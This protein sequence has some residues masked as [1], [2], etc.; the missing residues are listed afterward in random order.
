MPINELG[1][2]EQSSYQQSLD[3]GFSQAAPEKEQF[4]QSD[5]SALFTAFNSV[6][7][8][9]KRH[10]YNQA[11][12]DLSRY[13]GKDFNIDNLR[14]TLTEQGH[15]PS[16]I[17]NTLASPVT[18]WLEAE[19]R[20]RY[21]DNLESS[22]RQINQNYS[23]F[24]MLAVGI[25]MA[26]VDIDSLFISPMLAGVS[27]VNK[28]MNLSSK[29]AKVTSNVVAGGGVGAASMLTYEASTGVYDDGSLIE[30]T[31]VGAA[32]GG[33]LGMFI[34]KGQGQNL[35]RDLDD[36]GNVVS[37]EDKIIERMA[38]TNLQKKEVD[39][40]EAELSAL[41][42][43]EK[44]ATGDVKASTA[45][46]KGRAA[47]DIRIQKE[48]ALVQRKQTQK[49]FTTA[50]ATVANLD[51]KAIPEVARTI[52][53]VTKE[54]KVAQ[55]K[56]APV[57]K[58]EVF[59]AKV[60][61][62]IAKAERAIAGL[63]TKLQATDK[64]RGTTKQ[65]NEDIKAQRASI[66]VLKQ[67][68]KESQA[69]IK[70]LAVPK[71]T[72]STIG[73][74][75]GQN[76]SL[77]K[78]M[79]DLQKK[80]T[81]AKVTKAMA[82]KELSGARTKYNG[83]NPK[84][85]KPG[86]I[87]KSF[88][89]ASLEEKLASYGASL[90]PQGIRNLMEKKG[91]LESD[92][93]KMAEGDFNISSIR[94]LQKQKRNFIQKLSEELDEVGRTK[95]YEESAPYKSL[96]EWAQKLLISPIANL[97]HSTNRTVAGFA[98]KLH[99][100]TVHQGK[101]QTYTAANVKYMMDDKLNRMHKS[102]SYSWRQAVKEGYGGDLNKFTTEMMGSAYK[103]MGDIKRQYFTGIPADII[104]MERRKLADA[105]EGSIVRN[106]FH[107]NKWIVQGIDDMLDYYEG[108]HKKG[109][110]LGME[111]FVGSLGK[112]Y[113]NR[114][115]SLAKIT[116][117]G[118]VKA[119]EYLTEAQINFARATNSTLNDEVIA[120]F[121]A[122]AKTAIRGTLDR[123]AKYKQLTED[124]G[125]PVQ[126]TTSSLKQRGIDVFDDE[127]ADLLEDNL[128]G[129]TATYGLKAHG[130]I[131]LKEMLGVDRDSQIKGLID[132]LDPSTKDRDNLNVV[133]E[134]ILG[135]REMSKTP[136]D[137]FTRAIKGLGSLTSAMHT[138]GF[139]VPTVTEISSLA[140]EFG[141]GKTMN[142][143]VGT[144]K[145]IAELYRN[146]TPSER[147]TI[148]LMVSYGDIHFNRSTSRI[149]VMG[150][151]DSVGKLQEFLDD[152]VQKEAIYGGLLPVTDM[153]K[154]SAASLSVDF[155][156]GLSIQAKVS[157]T[158]RMRLQDMGF[159][160][161]DLPAIRKTLQVHPDGRIG[162][163]D[164]KTWGKMDERITLGV[165]EMV[166]RTIL[167]PDGATLPKFMTNM[168]GG[169]FV[170][171]IMMK[172]M[173]FP[174]ESYER[175]LIR[176]IQEADAKQ[177]MAVVGNVAMW[178][179]ILSM[180]D[181]IK[182]EDK[183]K[184]KGEEGLNAL[185]KDSFLYNSFTSLPVAMA[186]TVHGIAFGENLTN[187]YK[188][189]IGGAVTS[190]LNRTQQGKVRVSVPFGAVEADIAGGVNSALETL[191]IF[192]EFNKE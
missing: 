44:A 32:F 58:A 115:Y 107:E 123:E 42:K 139:V 87:T 191:N 59:Q 16:V 182:D 22:N 164:R 162:N 70:A 192:E 47:T 21:L 116:A 54:L 163:M 64:P 180:K 38:E 13:E 52:K 51:K 76:K 20:A 1:E 157:K 82:E 183:Q 102:I 130:R 10:E 14:T 25:P 145:Q 77:A 178:T 2:F 150:N 154:M 61:K 50:V 129:I 151:M 85:P 170:P 114:A 113:I 57:K 75:E 67:E 56:Y 45:N 101:A 118:E 28:V 131:A 112:G 104:G 171:R 43:K 15:T 46:D 41:Q 110:G 148:E 66:K 156:A 159:D 93:A 160:L 18:S 9:M 184:Y 69:S 80:S 137:P 186:D 29:A 167:H 108:I 190:T 31:L 125:A 100:S 128:A 147:N 12:V 24:G 79:E 19:R 135:T 173:R 86:E 176:G 55:A 181:A 78:Q 109:K 158:D 35:I 73:K 119:I 168:D 94:A 106:H 172:F 5:S 122:S 27:K 72:L 37:K 144:P 39:S 146:G 63:K 169:Q 90:S 189:N 99:T 111:A 92:I 89:T 81:T 124:F 155:I 152:V 187:D 141:W 165:M 33:T 153:L 48:K 177:M 126:S 88:E 36:N 8:L 83:L 26:L 4:K 71:D 134:T 11:E 30:S 133:I 96:P 105:R 65:I 84:A 49:D 23:T 188:H 140:K 149:D 3:R 60:T 174:F 95:S 127:I 179:A 142:S 103:T 34:E 166:N 138:L 6:G 117:M 62:A 91:A 74:L 121:A 132:Q 136:Y 143:L 185:A 120:G 161:E 53:A 98:S 40:I 7:A 97:L 68:M 17:E 175:L